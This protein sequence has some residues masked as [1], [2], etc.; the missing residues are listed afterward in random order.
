[1]SQSKQWLQRI[2]PWAVTAIALSMLVLIAIPISV[3]NRA[4][5]DAAYEGFDPELVYVNSKGNGSVAGVVEMS[6]DTLTLISVPGSTPTAYL[7][8]S[9][10]DQ[11]VEMDVRIRDSGEKT[12]PLSIQ[13][14]SPRTGTSFGMVFGPRPSNLIITRAFDGDKAIREKVLSSYSPSQE[15]RLKLD[16]LRRDGVIRHTLIGSE[17]PPSGN[18]YVVLTGGLEDPATYRE[19]FSEYISINEQSKQYIF[20]GTLKLGLGKGWYKL[21]V[22][23]F[24]ADKRFLSAS[25]DWRPP[26]DLNGWTPMKFD[27]TAPDGAAYAQ[28]I[29]GAGD[30]STQYY[31]TDL[32]LLEANS[33]SRNLLTNGDFSQ[34]PEGWNIMGVDVRPDESLHILAPS[35]IEVSDTITS[36][37]LPA[38]FWDLPLAVAVSSSSSEGTATAV[39]SDYQVI[40]PS[41]PWL[42]MKIA[43]AR[44]KGLSIALIVLGMLAVAVGVAKWSRVRLSGS[45]L[46]ATPKGQ[47]P[48][49]LSIH[50]TRLR[51]MGLVFV[52]ILVFFVLN[53]L[54][55]NLGYHTFDFLSE[56]IWSYIAAKY[57]PTNLYHMASLVT[58][59]DAWNGT[60]NGFA[61][62][63]YLAAMAYVFA[64]IG[65]ISRLFVAG[66]AMFGPG[67]G[68]MTFA[69]KSVN[70]LFVLADAF[71]VYGI[72]HSLKVR[73]RLSLVGAALLLFNPAIW[74]MTSIWGESHSISIF[75][76]LASI[77]FAVRRMPLGAWIALALSVLTRPQML[78]SAFFLGLFYIRQFSIRENISGFSWAVIG[79]FLLLAPF[80]LCFSPS[81]PIDMLRDVV[82][83][84]NP[85]NPEVGKYFSVS[86]S[87]YNLWPLLSDK[88]GGQTGM[89][90][91]YL[92][93]TTPLFGSITYGGFSNILFFLSIVVIAGTA[94]ALR[95][96]RRTD[97]NFI[98]LVAV[99][100][101]SLLM[102]RTGIAVHYLTFLIPLV[103][104]CRKSLDDWAYYAAIVVLTTTALV[105]MYGDF[106]IGMS[107][108]GYLMPAIA[109]ENN[110]VTNAF[111]HLFRSDRFITVG[112]TLNLLVFLYLFFIAVKPAIQ[113]LWD[114]LRR[115]RPPADETPITNTGP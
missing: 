54:L 29:L 37:E 6:P 16:I 45:E 73:Q 19:L 96:G 91:F 74:F 113:P 78:V 58:P 33:P 87:T 23:W 70:V 17:S 63:P 84:Q 114:R 102:L 79:A 2:A 95:K 112:S 97:S 55:F 44:A 98:I 28:M 103:L 115:G 106:G 34:G 41:Q 60:P 10:L 90:R 82:L 109:Y 56:G 39:L 65:W 69:I 83:T 48:V 47:V 50:V 51:L 13:T 43:D 93:S 59:A 38:L 71:L 14:W 64:G 20:G 3:W 31:V 11:H 52:A 94:L 25:N 108:V 107:Q 62:F 22:A 42:A 72:L 81:Y 110:P 21:V 75:F 5:N 80:T 30:K 8:T 68:Q 32:Y 85:T 35:Y 7:T 27:G 1:M 92:A 24:D 105:C 77:W 9:E 67:V 66:P 104:L 100:T 12:T 15:Y 46:W 101:M 4:E 40:I 76:V 53:G 57:G 26:T 99:G 89:G 86:L 49:T 88:L 18:S 111:I 36:D 61:I